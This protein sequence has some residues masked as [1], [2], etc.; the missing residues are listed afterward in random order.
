MFSN[1][2][3]GRAGRVWEDFDW[4]FHCF[5]TFPLEPGLAHLV[6]GTKHWRGREVVVVGGGCQGHQ[7]CWEGGYSLSSGNTGIPG[8]NLASFFIPTRVVKRGNI[9]LYFSKHGGPL[10]NMY[11]PTSTLN[12]FFYSH[13]GEVRKVCVCCVWLSISQIDVNLRTALVEKWFCYV[14]RFRIWRKKIISKWTM[15]TFSENMWRISVGKIWA[16]IL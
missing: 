9:K 11:W 16:R 12:E 7:N 15:C 2:G 5:L 13:K 3:R 14:G 1:C 4:S 10:G 8:G 6:G